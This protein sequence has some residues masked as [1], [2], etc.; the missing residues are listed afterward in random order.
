[1]NQLSDLL[2]GLRLAWAQVCGGDLRLVRE[3]NVRQRS[4]TVAAPIA[5]EGVTY[6]W[7]EASPPAGKLELARPLLQSWADLLGVIMGERETSEGLTNELIAAWNRL[8]FLHQVT[9]LRRTTTDPWQV[10]LESL[11]LAAQTI[12]AEN[13]FVAQL[14]D[15]ALAYDWI[16]PAYDESEMRRIIAALQSAGGILVR[17][18]TEACS[19]TFPELAGLH[20]FIGQQLQVTAG[21]PSFIGIINQAARQRFSAGDRQLFESLIETITTVVDVETLHI[22]QIEAEKQGRELEIAAE[23]Q[24]SFLPTTPPI[25]PDYELAATVIPASK[26]GGDLY[27][28]FQCDNGHTGLLV[29]DVAGKGISAALL[30]ASVRAT[31][32]AELQHASNPGEVLQSANAKLYGDMSRIER[33]VTA[34]L[35]CLPANRSAL[36]YASAGH[37]TGFWVRTEPLHVQ[38]LPST[39]LPLGILPEIEHTTVPID[40][41]PGDVVV[42]YSDGLSEAE[43]A[44]GRILGV[45]GIGDVLLATHSAP[46]RFILDSLTEAYRHHV[47]DAAVVDDLTLLV[48]KRVA[49]DTPAARYLSRL[50]LRSDLSLLS[51]VRVELDRLKSH[52]PGDS[53]IRAWL[54]EVQLAVTE[55]IANIIIHAYAR[56][57]GDIHG[58]VAL[59]PDRLQIDLFDVGESYEPREIPPLDFDPADPPENGYGLHIIRQVMDAVMFERLPDGHNHWRLMRSLP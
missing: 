32:R 54:M 46:A 45:A 6:A 22:Q 56:R 41:Q 29:C 51:D 28:V 52:L 16:H 4:A 50:H 24:T 31:I 26:I 58:L 39:T 3:P 30:A 7:L 43:N 57:A 40:V 44:Q 47:G 55:V 17:N 9:Q 10:S 36:Q 33:F 14:L 13:A 38:K 2:T 19:R 42:L 27:D 5:H 35:V 25:L 8:S 20:S 11:R 53:G 15:H 23:V 37:T 34:L 18:G 59:Y 12:E 21:P 1:M 48:L 49:G